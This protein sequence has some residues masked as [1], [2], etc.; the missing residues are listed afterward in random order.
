MQI[1][2]ST[3]KLRT[4]FFYLSILTATWLGWLAGRQAGWLPD[5]WGTG[6]G[7]GWW[8]MSCRFHFP[9]SISNP[10]LFPFVKLHNDSDCLVA[11]GTYLY[12]TVALEIRLNGSRLARI[13]CKVFFGF[14]FGSVVVAVVVVRDDDDDV[15]H[16]I[17]R[18]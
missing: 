11:V 3:W 4:F 17:K 8:Q 7:G 9:I 13:C 16:W 10:F 2:S 12:L 1:K 6:G 15:T 14:V 5:C 18:H